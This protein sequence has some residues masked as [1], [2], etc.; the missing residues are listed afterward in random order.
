[1]ARINE[2]RTHAARFARNRVFCRRDGCRTINIL[3]TCTRNKGRRR[4]RNA[5]G[6]RGVARKEIAR[7]RAT[8]VCILN[9]NQP[10]T[11]PR[12]SRYCTVSIQGFQV[13]GCRKTYPPFANPP[14]PPSF[15]CPFWRYF[16]SRQLL[17]YVY[18]RYG[19]PRLFGPYTVRPGVSVIFFRVNRRDKSE[20]CSVRTFIPNRTPLPSYVEWV[21][22][23]KSRCL[24]LEPEKA[25]IGDASE[26]AVSIGLGE[27]HNKTLRKAYCGRNSYS[28]SDWWPTTAHST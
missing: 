18:K 10:I 11:R 8:T 20:E 14:P 21:M 24:R 3:Y 5:S 22:L 25:F 17:W 13:S 6:D 9:F 12:W 28:L 7:G 16:V 27:V 15:G 19:T 4:R 23:H 2:S 26:C 1:M